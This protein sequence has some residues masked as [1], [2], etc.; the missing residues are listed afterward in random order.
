M[1]KPSQV[2]FVSGDSEDNLYSSAFTFIDFG[3][4]ANMFLRYCGVKSEPSVKDITLLLM[5][6]SQGMLRQAG[7]S[8]RYLEQLRLIAANWNRLDNQTRSAMKAAPFLLASQRIPMSKKSLSMATQPVIGGVDEYYREWVLC[9]AS[10]AVLVD[11]VAY[12]QYFGQYIL[13]AP[14]VKF[15]FI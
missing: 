4:K 3:L 12:A 10:E 2:Y 7:S 5:K 8:E 9:R 13:S 6:D 15:L 1:F 11:R 14:E